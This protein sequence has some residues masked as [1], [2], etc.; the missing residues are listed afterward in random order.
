MFDLIAADV[1]LTGGCDRCDELVAV[2]S[3]SDVPS[4]VEAGRLVDDVLFEF[5]LLVSE[6]RTTPRFG[7][8]DG[9]A[10]AAEVVGHHRR[11]LLLPSLVLLFRLADFSLVPSGCFAV[12][13]R[14]T[15]S[16]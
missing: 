4:V 15:V 7:A 2:A 9:L 10:T 1:L 3:D 12:T 6:S 13:N 8:G 14:V 11:V 5:L 16:G